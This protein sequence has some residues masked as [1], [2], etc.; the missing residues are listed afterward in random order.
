MNHPESVAC[1]TEMYK[2]LGEILDVLYPYAY[3]ESYLEHETVNT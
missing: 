2:E 3:S 1:Y